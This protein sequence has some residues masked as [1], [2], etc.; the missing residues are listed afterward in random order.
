MPE[1]VLTS[2]CKIIGDAEDI[3]AVFNKI[4]PSKILLEGGPYCG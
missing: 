3:T 2:D 1:I 4:H